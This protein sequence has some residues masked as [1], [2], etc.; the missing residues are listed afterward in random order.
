[1][2]VFTNIY[3]NGIIKQQ[4]IN[5]VLAILKVYIFRQYTNILK[6]IY[7]ILLKVVINF[8]LDINFNQIIDMIEKRKNN[9]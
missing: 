7:L 5:R 6:L 3:T 2:N 4:K 8:M 9:A 1:M